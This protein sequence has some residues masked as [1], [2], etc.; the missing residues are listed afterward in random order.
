MRSSRPGGPVS[1]LHPVVHLSEIFGTVDD[2]FARIDSIAVHQVSD[3]SFVASLCDQPVL[4]RG[5]Q[6]IVRQIR[7]SFF[8]ASDLSTSID[9][10]QNVDKCSPQLVVTVSR[11]P[12]GSFDWPFREDRVRSGPITLERDCSLGLLS[13]VHEELATAHV[14]FEGE[15]PS[16]EESAPL[17]RVL[18]VLVAPRSIHFLHAGVLA[19]DGFGLLLPGKGGSGKSTTVAFAS[20][21]GW[22]TIGDDFIAFKDAGSGSP[23]LPVDPIV[24]CLYRTFRLG[25]SSPAFELLGVAA[26]LASALNPDAKAVGHFDRLFP[27]S[28]VQDVRLTA[29]VV[30]RVCPSQTESTF[31]AI[32]RAVSLRALA[33]SSIF[34]SGSRAGSL[35]S[36]RR[37]LDSIPAFSLSIGSD[38]SSM[39]EA[40]E[41]IG[42]I[43]CTNYVASSIGG[44]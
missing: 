14:W 10:G 31:T 27:N 35:P 41:A 37:L 15:I 30:P 17:R 32:S 38:V 23:E 8:R 5:D 44:V 39:L 28:L 7:S 19:K 21:A 42:Q 24:S 20:A 22:Q 2:C 16:W 40:L 33:P 26:P 9:D 29:S 36:M 34:L 11:H 1:P 4:I 25:P 12:I 6:G 43:S 13:A 18:H 3:A